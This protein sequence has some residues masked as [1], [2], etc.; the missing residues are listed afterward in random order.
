MKL[1]SPSSDAL[2]GGLSR[3]VPH[4]VETLAFDCREGCGACCIAP[5]ISSPI[6]MP[7]EGWPPGYRPLPSGGKPAGVPCPQL[8]ASLRCRLFGRPERPLVCGSLQPNA[9]MC[10]RDRDE[11][12]AYLQR[13]ENETAP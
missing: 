3:P 12:L 4:V 11:A 6:P 10:G 7:P 8:D 13:M 9:E 1:S 2:D 5:S